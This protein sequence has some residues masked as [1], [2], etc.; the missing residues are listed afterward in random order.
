MDQLTQK[1][2]NAATQEKDRVIQ[3]VTDRAANL[4]MEVAALNANLETAN[5]K[6]FE[7]EERCGEFER[8]LQMASGQ[9]A[10]S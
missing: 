10:P 3:F 4:A 6:I 8:L 9:G 7:L 1:L 5:S 2:I